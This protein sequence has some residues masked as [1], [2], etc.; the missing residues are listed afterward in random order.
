MS[1]E[2]PVLDAVVRLLEKGIFAVRVA[3]IADETGMDVQTVD[4]ALDAL[5]GTYIRKYNKMMTGGHP[6]SWYVTEV[7]SAARRAVGQWPTGDSLAKSLADAFDDV[8]DHEADPDRKSRLRQVAGFL[9]DTG[10]DVAAEVLARLIL[11]PAGM[12]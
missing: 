8:A 7:T 2:L 10:K 6:D 5:T 4:R 1:R 9:G 12:G 11:R 3:D